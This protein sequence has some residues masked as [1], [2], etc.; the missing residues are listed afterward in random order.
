MSVENL[1]RRMAAAD[2]DR[3]MEIAESLDGAPKWTRS[4]YL[5]AI[6]PAATRRRVALVAETESG[7]VGF[8]VASLLGPEAE[9]ETIAVAA[10]AHRL[11]IGRRLVTEMGAELRRADVTKVLLEV[12]A[13]NLPALELYRNSGFREIG[14]RTLYYVDP[15]EDAVLM[16]MHLS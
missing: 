4:A 2:V 14:R 8:A 16:S 10:E 12:R 9:L 1:I 5:E 6:D 15:I 7:L 11:G 13:G 3:A